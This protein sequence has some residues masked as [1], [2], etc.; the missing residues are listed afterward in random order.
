M[1]CATQQQFTV[2]LIRA[3]N[4]IVPLADVGHSQ[5]V[6]TSVNLAGRVVRL[7][8]EEQA[9]SF[10]DSR[11]ECREV[12]LIVKSQSMANQARANPNS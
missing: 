8:H 3:D 1:V 12:N 11:L 10:R 6:L 2:Y 7:T 9:C 4:Q 5:Q